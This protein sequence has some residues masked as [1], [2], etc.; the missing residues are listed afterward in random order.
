MHCTLVET[1]GTQTDKQK[2]SNKEMCPIINTV[3]KEVERLT[4]SGPK[5]NTF[6]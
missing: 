6:R 2:S 3:R 4:K 1:M 5:T